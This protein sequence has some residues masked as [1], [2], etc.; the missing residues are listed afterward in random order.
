MRPAVLG[1]LALVFALVGLGASIASLIDTLSPAPTFCSEGG[2]ELVRSS[3][4]ATPLGIPLPLIGIVY[5]AAM[6]VL[7]FVP[8]RRTRIALA[9]VGGAGGLGLI[10]IQAFSIGAWCK[11]CLVA[12][13]AAIAG[14]IVVVAGAGTVR[15][16]WPNIAATVPAAGLVVLALGLYSHRDMPARLAANEPMPA[17]VAKEQQPGVVTIVEFV[18]F[19]CPFCRRLH[20][21]LEEILA[22]YAGKVR[23]VRKQQPLPTLHPHAVTAAHAACCA[24]EQGAAA[25]DKMAAA[26]YA[27]DPDQLTS[28]GCEALAAQAGL[29]VAAWKSCMASERPAKRVAAD[30]AIARAGDFEG[31][32][33][34]FFI[35]PHKFVG[36]KEEGVIRAAIEREL[37]R[38]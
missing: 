33:P 23:V 28:E 5:F 14:A 6:T 35:G 18:D 13:P 2:C 4:W 31:T 24:D 36:A 38:R 11:L 7:A 30:Q 25:G 17:S 32:A 3:A 37:A 20:H 26:L 1:V 27:A 12:D 21:T 16:T 10:A 8:R 9:I 19:E 15:P 22:D 34:V 29:D